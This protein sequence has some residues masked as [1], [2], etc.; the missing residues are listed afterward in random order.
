MGEVYL[1]GEEHFCKKCV[2]LQKYYLESYVEAAQGGKIGLGLE[3]IVT[4]G[5]KVI[6]DV[7]LAIQ[8]HSSLIYLA[9]KQGIP[10]H[11]LGFPDMPF[12]EHIEA[13]G[14]RIKHLS[15]DYDIFMAVVGMD[16]YVYYEDKPREVGVYM[17]PLHVMHD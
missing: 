17:I 5:T 15:Q 6:E 4:P 10:V 3:A 1:I 7:R 2:S 14:N 13:V 9:E 16:D 12:H 11:A 8:N